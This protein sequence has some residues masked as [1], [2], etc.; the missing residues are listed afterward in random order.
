MLNKYLSLVQIKIGKKKKKQFTSLILKWM[1]IKNA[2]QLGWTK[3]LFILLKQIWN[4]VSRAWIKQ[5][6][7]LVVL[8]KL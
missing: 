4:Y 7:K 5:I 1:W 3:V 6:F 2:I 8:T